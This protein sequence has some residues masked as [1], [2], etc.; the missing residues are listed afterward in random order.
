MKDATFRPA[1]IA[2]DGKSIIDSSGARVDYASRRIVHAWPMGLVGHRSRLI[3][4]VFRKRKLNFRVCCG[5]GSERLKYGRKICTGR[6]CV[7]FHP[8]SWH[9]CWLRSSCIQPIMRKRPSE[10]CIACGA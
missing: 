1:R 10:S 9:A 6:E 5:A 7:P 4:E 3:E 2:E 8:A